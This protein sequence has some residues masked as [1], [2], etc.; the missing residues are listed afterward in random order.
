MIAVLG[1]LNRILA[2]DDLEVARL[3]TLGKLLDLVARVVDIELAPDICA[4]LL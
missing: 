4:G 1:E 2:L 3:Q